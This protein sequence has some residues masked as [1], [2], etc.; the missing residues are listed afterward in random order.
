MLKCQRDKFSITREYAYLNGAYMSPNLK[1]VHDEGLEGLITKSFPYEV[2]ID[3]FFT[4]PRAL[5]AEFSKLINAKDPERIAIIPS[6]SYGLANAAHNIPI[7]ANQNIILIGEQFPSNVYIWQKIA[8][9]KNAKIV[10]VNPPPSTGNRGK[11]WN[12]R[13]LSTIDSNTK[14]VAMAIVHWAD[15]TLFDVKAIRQ[16]AKEVGAYFI[17]DGTQS[18]GALP[19]DVQE[20]QP[21]ALICAGYKWLLGPY[22]L[23]VAYYGEAFDNG[24][25]IEENWVNRLNSHEFENLI[26]YQSEYQPKAQRYNVGES[27]NFVLVPMLT[28]SIRQLNEW[29]VKNVNDYC[30]RL[31]QKPLR[32]LVNMGCNIEASE[33]VSPHL[34]GVRLPRNIDMNKLQQ[35]FSDNRVKVS[36]RGNSIRISP[37]VYNDRNDFDRLIECFSSVIT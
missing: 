10:T 19:F 23:G 7:E 3:D 27:S 2:L 24:T 16:R 1:S 36:T 4:P 22:S 17:L 14:V 9:E 33:Y 25:P 30:N 13:L 29:N 8:A 6:A 21:D 32:L 15:G 34:F 20:V 26:N 18:V 5:R 28:E 31:I 12:E 37:N 35:A 11:I